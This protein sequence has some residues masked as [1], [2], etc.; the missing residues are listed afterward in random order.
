M[1]LLTKLLP[2]LLIV[3]VILPGVSPTYA[4]AAYTVQPGDTLVKISIRFGVTTSAILAANHIT[5]PNLIYVGQQLI[6]PGVSAS[7]PAATTYV[8]QSGD[9]LSKIAK[10]LGVSSAAIMA[11]N[12]IANANLIYIGQRLTIPG[13]SGNPVSTTVAPAATVPPASPG[14][15]V[16]QPG[17]TLSKIAQKFGVTYQALLAANRIANPSLI[18]IGQPLT[19]PGGGSAPATPT[20]ILPTATLVPT[21]FVPTNTPVPTGNSSRGIYGDSFSIATSGR[22]NVQ[23]W[24]DFQVTNNTDTDISYGMLSAHTDVGP[25]GKSWSG[26]TLKARQTL[27]W[28]DHLQFS[29]IGTY[30]VYLGICYDS[31]ASCSTGSRTWD[32]LSNSVS[33]TISN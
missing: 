5:N 21:T 11:A 32:R 20:S 33:V 2:V 10:R 6:I 1:K 19:I 24:F 31:P 26:A 13:A 12:G 9:S 17:D 3:A 22:V 16:V 25:T 15:Y 23:V 4:D 8:V 29:S 7:A 27:A 14:T 28:H 30:Q 18:Y